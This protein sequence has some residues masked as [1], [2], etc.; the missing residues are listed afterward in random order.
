MLLPTGFPALS[1]NVTRSSVSC[2]EVFGGEVFR[3]E[4]AFAPPASSARQGVTSVSDFLR[5]GDQPPTNCSESRLRCQAASLLQRT[6]KKTHEH[7]GELRVEL[8]SLPSLHLLYPLLYVLRG[9]LSGC[10]RVKAGGLI[11]PVATLLEP[12]SNSQPFAPAATYTQFRVSNSERER[13]PSGHKLRTRR[14]WESNLQPSCCEVH[15]Y[16]FKRVYVKL[17]RQEE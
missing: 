1:D 7:E 6:A 10:H 12:H 9:L 11:G 15:T 2:Q 14:P 5:A 8:F 17:L 3:G 16:I 4:S 13:E